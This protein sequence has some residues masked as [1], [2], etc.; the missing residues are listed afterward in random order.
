ML[1]DFYGCKFGISAMGASVRNCNAAGI[2]TVL[3]MVYPCPGDDYHTRAEIELFIESVK[4]DSV[5][6]ELPAL[7]PESA[8]FKRPSE[9]GFL[10][11]HREYH[12][13]VAGGNSS[14]GDLPYAMRGWNSKRIHQ[15]Q[16]SLVACALK[17]GCLIDIT[18]QQGLMARLI[19][20]VMNETEFLEGLRDALE[21]SDGD[22][23]KNLALCAHDNARTLNTG[24][25]AARELVGSIA[26]SS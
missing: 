8:W 11:N 10:V 16:A 13:H 20:S 5:C 24:A 4:P 18:E 7:A 25:L 22:R 1:E 2:F 26:F 23:L 14:F 6:I 15:T 17:T 19:R 3:R 9:F 12:R 21:Q